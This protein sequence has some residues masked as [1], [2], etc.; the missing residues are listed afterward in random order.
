MVCVLHVLCVCQVVVQ[1]LTEGLDEEGEDAVLTFHNLHGRSY[2]VSA[3]VES[4]TGPT[5]S[6]AS[7]QQCIQLPSKTVYLSHFLSVYLSIDRSIDRSISL[8]LN[9]SIKDFISQ[10]INH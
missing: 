9:L 6:E 1:S 8:T 7:P 5:I 4:R 2:C 3:T 10:Y